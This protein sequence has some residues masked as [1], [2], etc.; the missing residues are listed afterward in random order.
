MGSTFHWNSKWRAWLTKKS[1][2]YL[3][4]MKENK[5][6]NTSLLHILWTLIPQIMPLVHNRIGLNMVWIVDPIPPRGG[7]DARSTRPW[8]IYST[9]AMWVSMD[10]VHPFKLLESLRPLSSSIM[11]SENV[12]TISTHE[13]FGFQWTRKLKETTPI[14][15]DIAAYVHSVTYPLHPYNV[16][17]NIQHHA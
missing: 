11:W 10:D 17:H 5:D 1:L 4:S 8:I 2:F 7:L 15:V 6:N 16:A 12:V 9:Y 14:M 3:R 13:R